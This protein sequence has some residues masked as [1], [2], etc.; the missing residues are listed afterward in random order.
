MT[1]FYFKEAVQERILVNLLPNIIFFNLKM[2]H[3]V[4]NHPYVFSV[5]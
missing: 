2:I 1:D 3:F 5:F 4:P